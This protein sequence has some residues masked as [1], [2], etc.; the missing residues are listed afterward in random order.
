MI[1]KP[2][3]SSDRTA[4][5]DVHHRLHHMLTRM[6]EAEQVTTDIIRDRLEIQSQTLRRNLNNPTRRFVK[7][8]LSAFNI[9]ELA[10]EYVF[11]WIFYGSHGPS[12]VEGDCD[13]FDS[14]FMT[15]RE[16][17]IVRGLVTALLK[18]RSN[19]T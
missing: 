9:S 11:E 18:D 14:R 7:Q 3:F 10:D 5:T 4:R 15:M 8:F 6:E 2:S 1:S 17:D 13:V 16:R 19:K 12:T